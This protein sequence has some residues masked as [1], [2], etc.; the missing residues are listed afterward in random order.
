V[1]DV[2]AQSLGELCMSAPIPLCLAA[3]TMIIALTF[4][5]R[6]R[7]QCWLTILEPC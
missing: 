3:A 7:F 2:V 5:R 6:Y 4:G 1:E